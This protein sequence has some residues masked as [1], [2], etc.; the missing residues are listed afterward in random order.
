MHGTVQL[1]SNINHEA[2]QAFIKEGLSV[3][4]F[5]RSIS[6]DSHDELAVRAGEAAILGVRSGPE[7]PSDVI[8]KGSEGALCAIGCFCTGTSHV[9][10]DAATEAGMPVFNAPGENSNAVAELVMI[11]TL[12]LFRRMKMHVI[13]M[14]TRRWTKTDDNS[15]EVAGKTMG[16]VGHGEIGSL[17]SQK[18]QGLGMNVVF[19]D[20]Q[21]QVPPHGAE[22]LDSIEELLGMADVT[23]LHVP[24]GPKTKDLI[25]EERLDAMKE[26]AYLINASRYSV[27]NMAAIEAALDSGHLGGLALDV[28]DEEPAS[29][30]DDFDHPLSDRENVLLTP[31]IGGSTVDAQTA[32]AVNTSRKLINHLATGSTIGAVNV[33][34]LELGEIAPETSRIVS[35]HALDVDLE[36]L[37]SRAGLDV[38]SKMSASNGQIAYSSVDVGGVLLPEELAEYTRDARVNSARVLQPA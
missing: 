8:K 22:R 12:M 19:F 29:F 36:E 11:D 4:T 2:K 1:L 17:V 10:M 32:I 31:H 14:H 9:D 30:G 20:P 34:E 35:V 24:G 13:G 3:E 5:P 7:V 25:N 18:A 16:I 28:Y 38:L 26:G 15:H 21:P 23:T 6:K 37:I 27:V 33:P